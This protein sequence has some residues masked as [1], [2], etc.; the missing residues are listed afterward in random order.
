VLNLKYEDYIKEHSS[1]CEKLLDNGD[2]VLVNYD[3][4]TI[5]TYV[6]TENT[7]LVKSTCSTQ[8]LYINEGDIVETD[9][10]FVFCGLYSETSYMLQ[11]IDFIKVCFMLF[12]IAQK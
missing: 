12:Q 8:G 9:G 5:D 6:F 1:T 3:K 10:E 7:G 2:F 4:N 11:K